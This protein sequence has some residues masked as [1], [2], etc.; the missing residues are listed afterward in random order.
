MVHAAQLDPGGST[1]FLTAHSRPDLFLDERIEDRVQ[2]GVEIALDT[3]SLHQVSPQAAEHHSL[4]N[5]IT[6]SV[7]RAR[8][9]GTTAAPNPDTAM[10]PTIRVRIHGSRASTP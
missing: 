1:G 2:F 4:L 3:I 6:G 7:L 8:R 9:T 10:T 5:A